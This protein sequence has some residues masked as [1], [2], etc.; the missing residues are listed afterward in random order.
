MTRRRVIRRAA[1]ALK[2]LHCFAWVCSATVGEARHL[3]IQM[4]RR[5]CN[6]TALSKDF[7]RGD[8]SG[9]SRCTLGD[10]YCGAALFSLL[11]QA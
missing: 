1:K 6:R 4:A 11:P 10:F 3:S 8:S 5:E 2:T 7:G 9:G